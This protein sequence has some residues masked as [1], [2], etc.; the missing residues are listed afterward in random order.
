MNRRLSEI[1]SAPV[2]AWYAAKKA[3]PLVK[4][5]VLIVLL[6][7]LAIYY[8]GCA[9]PGE[10]LAV[11]TGILAPIDDAHHAAGVRKDYR[12]L[13]HEV[14]FACHQTAP[15]TDERPL[16]SWHWTIPDG[17]TQ[18]EDRCRFCHRDF[19][20]GGAWRPTQPALHPLGTPIPSWQ[21]ARKAVVP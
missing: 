15:S 9:G 21:P 17:V 8:A 1:L 18:A 6:L 16:D 2:A 12:I 4:M 10:V 11:Q 19:E 13:A 7:V 14:C 5:G 3:D 20:V